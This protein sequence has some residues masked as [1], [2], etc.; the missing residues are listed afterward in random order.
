MT[1]KLNIHKPYFFVR[2]KLILTRGPNRARIQF[3]VTQYQ[4]LRALLQVPLAQQLAMAVESHRFAVSLAPHEPDALFNSAQVISYLAEELSESQPASSLELL[5]DANWHLQQCLQLQ[6]EALRR[7]QMEVELLNGAE[8]GV[9]VE[10]GSTSTSRPETPSST[11]E[12]WATV[13][14]P[15]TAAALVETCVAIYETL[16]SLCK[17]LSSDQTAS[18]QRLEGQMQTLTDKVPRFI[19]DVEDGLKSEL[20][21][22]QAKLKAILLESAFERGIVDVYTYDRGLNKAFEELES[23]PGAVSL[24]ARAEAL[25]AFVATTDGTLNLSQL[26][27]NRLT[28]ALDLLAKATKSSQ[29]S[30][31]FATHT[32]RGDIELMRLRLLNKEDLP[33]SLKSSSV[34]LTLLNNAEKY[35]RGANSVGRRLSSSSKDQHVNYTTLTKEALVL[36]ILQQSPQALE[37]LMTTGLKSSDITEA[38]RE[39][40]DELLVSEDVLN[41]CGLESV[42]HRW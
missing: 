1:C 17:L 33:E 2:R 30:G 24:F 34:P 29:S 16:T 28:K 11:Q 3:A 21:I 10:S 8:G 13:K 31:L 25:V 19:E 35:Y 23:H 42:L 18:L 9:S 32:L 27:W 20:Y 15:L 22:A 5:E 6:E 7:Q 40:V 4:G 36:C 39:C 38:L 37:E 26:R 14:E 41:Q 12:V